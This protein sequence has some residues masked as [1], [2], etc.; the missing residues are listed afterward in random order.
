[1]CYCPYHLRMVIVEDSKLF[2]KHVWRKSLMWLSLIH[3]P[4]KQKKM[5]KKNP[6]FPKKEGS[7]VLFLRFTII[8]KIIII[9]IISTEFALYHRNHAKCF[10]DSFFLNIWDYLNLIFSDTAISNVE[11]WNVFHSETKYPNNKLYSPNSSSHLLFTDN[12][13]EKSNDFFKNESTLYIIFK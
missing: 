5:K 12:S 1:M 9:M 4:P 2:T 6:I 3:I 13:L 7:T 11:L 10:M 8:A